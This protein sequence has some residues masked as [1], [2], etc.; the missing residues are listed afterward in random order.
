MKLCPRCGA[1]KPLEEFGRNAQQKSGRAVYCRPC[2]TAL[3]RAWR[4]KNRERARIRR[5]SEYQANREK[6]IEQAAAWVRANPERARAHQA[7]FRKENRDYYKAKGQERRALL[8][9][10]TV[11]P[12]T[13]TELLESYAQ[14]DLAGCTYCGGPYEHDDH[15]VPLARGGLHTIENL[16]PAC[17]WCNCSKGT[18]LVAEWLELLRAHR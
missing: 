4:E 6:A 5:A 10:V 7:K 15:V 11:E 16:V 18:K 13:R 17:A 9:S 1:T 12:F 3:T 2:G 8:A 14:R